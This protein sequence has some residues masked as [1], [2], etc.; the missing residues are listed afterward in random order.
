M[1]ED[2]T[3]INNP[4]FLYKAGLH[5]PFPDWVASEPMPEKSDFEKKAATAFADPSRRLLPICTASA[6][7]HSAIN[8]F[9]CPDDFD[10]GA[11]ERVKE[12]CAYY[13]I[14]Q[15]ILPYAQLFVEE[16]DKSAALE[17]PE[18][19][20]FAI[21]E[22]IN[23]D[24][25]KLLPLNDADD[26]ASSAFDLAKMASEN[27]IHILMFV[28]AAREIVKAASDYGVS[29]LPAII[30]RYGLP[31]FADAENACKLIRDR[32]SLCKDASLRETIANDYR[33]ALSCIETDADA[34]FEKIA[35]IDTAAGITTGYKLA[36][37]VP[38]PYDI[39]FSGALESEAEKAAAENVLIRDVLVP[40]S[41]VRRIGELDAKFKLSKQAAEELVKLRDTGDA[42]DLSIAVEN[43]EEEDQRTFLRLAVAS[44]S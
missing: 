35:A 17:T 19:G 1:S 13:G 24:N 9:A 21:D 15:D 44:A 18:E 2:F 16:M 11:M 40:L 7:F 22:E 8:I 26:V 43:W 25:F 39:V 34:S 31:K 33:E 5:H 23:G 28:P 14:E 37:R 41:E 32:E 38:N 6:A 27:R 3:S 4:R 30:Y 10:E 36:A 20:W 29:D 12:A 42:K